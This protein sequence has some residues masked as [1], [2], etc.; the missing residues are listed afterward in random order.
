MALKVLI[1]FATTCEC[2]AAFSTLLHFKTKYR[3]RLNV[4]ND[5]R[6]ARCKT[7]PKMDELIAAKQAH[8]SH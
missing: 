7:N 5:M 6:V 4:T 2:E 8:P 1:P 3:N